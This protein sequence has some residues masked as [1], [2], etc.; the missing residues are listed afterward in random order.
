MIFFLS[1]TEFEYIYKSQLTVHPT[2]HTHIEFFRSGT[3]PSFSSNK[4]RTL[5][6]SK[7]KP[8]PESRNVSRRGTKKIWDLNNTSKLCSKVAHLVTEG[9]YSLFIHTMKKILSLF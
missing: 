5:P 3:N 2:Q 9:N 6:S 8:E 4:S 7:E 1:I